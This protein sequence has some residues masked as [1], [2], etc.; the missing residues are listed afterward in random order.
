MGKAE[1]VFIA[2]IAVAAIGLFN[3]HSNMEPHENI[4]FEIWKEKNNKQYDSVE[5]GYRFQVWLKNFEYVRK[6]NTRYDAGL[7]TFDLEMNLYADLT[8]E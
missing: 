3:L 8:N 2:L 5:H 6:H 7:E 1:L 4:M